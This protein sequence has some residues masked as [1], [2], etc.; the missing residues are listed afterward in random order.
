MCH[1]AAPPPALPAAAEAPARPAAAPAATAAAAQHFVPG[2]PPRRQ[3]C[4]RQS[5]CCRLALHP[6]LRRRRAE[7]PAQRLPWPP[8]PSPQGGGCCNARLVCRRR[9]CLSAGRAVPPDFHCGPNVGPPRD[10]EQG[11]FAIR[12]MTRGVAAVHGGP[13]HSSGGGSRWLSRLPI[14]EYDRS[15]AGAYSRDAW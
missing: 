1:A 15:C 2:R 13:C 9:N 14:K 5:C 7:R 10:Y 6:M 3:H 8:P 12:F 4:R 11:C